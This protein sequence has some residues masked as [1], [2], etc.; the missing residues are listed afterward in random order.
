MCIAC[1]C[2]QWGSDS[3]HDMYAD[4]V[5]AVVLQVQTHA[6]SMTIDG[7]PSHSWSS[8]Q[9]TFSRSVGDIL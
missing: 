8:T 1:T 5:L 6:S 2:L 7:K 3:V 4:A 9:Q